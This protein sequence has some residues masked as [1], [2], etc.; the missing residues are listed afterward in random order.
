MRYFFVFLLISFVLGCSSVKESRQALNSGDYDTSIKIAVEHLRKSKIRKRNQTY[1][2]ILKDAFEKVQKR[3]LKRIQFLEKANNAAY[4]EEIYSL[5]EKLVGRQELIEPLLPLSGVSFDFKDYTSKLLSTQ[6]KL[7]NYLYEKALAKFDSDTKMG[8]REAYALLQ[9]I[10]NLKPNFKDIK[11][12]MQ[13]AHYRGQDFV[14]V[15]LFNDTEKVIPVRLEGDLLNFSAYGLNDFWTVYD[16]ERDANTTYDFG[17]ELIFRE[18]NLTPEHI[19]ER[20]IIREKQ[21][22]DGTEDVKDAEGNVLV[23]SLGNR[24]KQDRYITVKGRIYEFNQ[25]KECRMSAMVNY[26]DMATNKVLHNFPISSHYVFYNSY[27]EMSGDKRAFDSKLLTIIG[28]QSL[29][30]PSDEQMI[31]DAGMD[32]KAKFKT[33]MLRNHF[34]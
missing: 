2:P 31:F 12:K 5:Y 7:A 13:E 23:D 30:F 32:L 21:V 10:D 15:T 1:I 27:G 24:L 19:K 20:E 22:K 14:L 4:I 16:A 11:V 17:L 3:D 33:I 25:H 26:V 28:R 29:P 34:R 6:L 18:I 9:E 8:Y